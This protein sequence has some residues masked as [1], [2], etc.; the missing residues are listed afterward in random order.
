MNQPFAD[1][2]T[3]WDPEIAPFSEKYHSQKTPSK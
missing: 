1:D 2:I 3:V